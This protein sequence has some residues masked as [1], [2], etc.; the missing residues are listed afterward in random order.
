MSVP[1]AILGFVADEDG[2]WVALLDC[3]HRRHVRHR[4]PLSSYAWVLDPAGREAHLG[5][6]IEC[7]RCR[8]RTW[9]EGLVHHRDT[10]WFDADTIPAGLRADH[11]VKTGTW[12]RLE[13]SEGALILRFAGPLGAKVRVEA[14]E[15]AAIPPALSH[16]VEVE[17]PV[18][19]RVQFWRVP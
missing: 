13:V 11:R 9:P 1:R 15:T 17:G 2:D 14:G 19:F 8:Q 4:P 3:G 7:D 6:A 10:S 18:R 16:R 12:G 5:Q